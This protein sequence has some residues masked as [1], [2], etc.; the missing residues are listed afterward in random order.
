MVTGPSKQEVYLEAVMSSRC[1]EGG[2]RDADCPVGGLHGI[3]AVECGAVVKVHGDGSVVG[4]SEVVS[5]SEVQSS[6]EHELCS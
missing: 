1:N 2:E 3:A 5:R 4:A 6:S